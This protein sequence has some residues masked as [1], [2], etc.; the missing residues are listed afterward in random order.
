MHF[1]EFTPLSR[2]RQERGFVPVVAGGR[3]REGVLPGDQ[4][5]VDLGVGKEGALPL[6]SEALVYR[7]WT[8][9]GICRTSAVMGIGCRP[10]KVT[11][12]Q[13]AR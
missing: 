2:W 6:V 1:L 5:V 10:T 9:A 11:L 7:C 12:A 4:A 3:L 13:K 8:P